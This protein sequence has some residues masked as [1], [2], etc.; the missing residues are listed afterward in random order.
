MQIRAIG[1]IVSA[2]PGGRSVPA[3]IYKFGDF[4]LDP[5]RFELRRKGH[6]QKLERIPMELLILLAEKEGS[7]ATR[8]EIVE[9]LWGK[10][11]FVDTEHGINTAVRKIRQALRDDPEQ[12]RFVQTVTGKGYRFVAERNGDSGASAPPAMAEVAAAG[13][14]AARPAAAP[15]L[16]STNDSSA[17]VPVAES[18]SRGM[19]L[20]APAVVVVVVAATLL[21]FNAGGVRDRLF[22]G[23]RARQ[24]HSIAVLPLSNL[25]GDASQEYFADGMTDEVITMLAKNTSLRVVSRT[26]AMQYKSVKRPLP[27]I[28]RELGVDGIL[29]GSIQ[30]SPNRVHMTVQLIYAP[31]DTHVWAESYDRDLNAAVSLPSELSQTIAKEVKN[32][33]SP[34]PRQRVINPEAHDSYLHGRYF[35]FAGNDQRSQEYFEKAIQIQPDYA[36]AWAGLSASYALR[37]VDDEAPYK[38]LTVKAETAARKAVE[39]DDS[40]PEAHHALAAWYLFYA[41]DLPHAEVE[42]R[43]ATELDPN[44]AEQH[45]LRSY[46]LMAMNRTDEAL[47]EQKH[48]TEL[49]PFMRSWGLGHAYIQLRQFDSAINELRMRADAMPNEAMI[50]FNLANAYW[51]KGM[52]NESVRELEK[53]LELSGD[54]KDAEAEH[55]A[56]QEGGEKAVEQLGVKEILARAQKEYVSPFAIARQYAYLGDRANTLKFL[57]QSFREHYPWLILVQAEP[58][59]DFVRNE[60]RYQAVVKNMGLTLVD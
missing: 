31:T 5:S 52:W 50:R 58:D 37:G 6:V 47:Q 41:W 45:H 20:V 11:V 49:D 9:R 32:A 1:G 36:P 15:L 30:R 26:S 53:A 17:A 34:A 56:F 39:L 2:S 59:F 29:E 14:P 27:D 18:K 24:I 38:D 35:W 22:P 12:P 25:S 48:A 21:G 4:E 40:L 51:H 33:T 54:S 7:I 55:K 10:E 19:M 43:R 28:A 57:E 46:V 13:R 42:S 16:A 60:P 8:Q 23:S 3:C 44:I